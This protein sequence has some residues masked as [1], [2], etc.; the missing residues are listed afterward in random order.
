M[1]YVSIVLWILGL[2]KLGEIFFWLGYKMVTWAPVQKIKK[3]TRKQ[4]CTDCGAK[5]GSSHR[6]EC[7]SLAMLNKNGRGY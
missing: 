2:I 7:Y 6:P 3:H 4:P 1:K 5:C